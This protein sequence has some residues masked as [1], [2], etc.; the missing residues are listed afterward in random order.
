MIAFSSLLEV[1]V[2]IP[3]LL[4]VET[5]FISGLVA[6]ISCIAN[7]STA[8]A[9]PPVYFHSLPNDYS[10]VSVFMKEGEFKKAR[11]L[12]IFKAFIAD[13]Y[14]IS[15][16]RAQ[17]LPFIITYEGLK[18]YQEEIKGTIHG[19]TGKTSPTCICD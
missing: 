8:E 12:R 14:Q 16:L 5:N 10:S 3:F 18:Q 9:Q 4:K 13:K 17:D 19:E 11:D 1:N 7:L 6:V 2:K 15:D